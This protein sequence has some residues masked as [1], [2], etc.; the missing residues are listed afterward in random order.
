M[1]Q[2]IAADVTQF[3]A[4]V[5]LAFQRVESRLGTWASD[6][7]SY[8]SLLR[9]V[10]GEESTNATKA[11]AL[12]V[13]LRGTGL[14]IS[15]EILDGAILSGNKGAYTNSAPEG[16]ECIYLNIDWLQSATPEQIEAV[17]LEEIGH[18]IDIRLNGQSDSPGDEGEIF[19]SLIRSI[20]PNPSATTENDQSLIT[21]KGLTVAIEA[22]ATVQVALSASANGNE[23]D[24]SPVVFTFSRTGSTD[25]A[26][27]VGYQL[28]GSARAGSD[29]S[30][31]STGTITFAAGSATATLSL[32]ALADGALID[33]G[34]TIIARID[35]SGSYSITPFKQFATAT[36]T[37]EGM[38]VSPKA[39]RYPEWSSGEVN[40]RLAFA[41]LKSDGSVVSWGDSSTGGT[42]PTGLSGVTQ[43]F[44]TG[45][46]FAALKSDGSVVS[47]GNS[48][49]GGTAPTGLS[50]VT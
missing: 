2:L 7:G 48:S 11:M 1:P 17:L 8:N 50:G 25:A 30:G 47:W 39:S 14:A 23:A 9:E 43:I 6:S 32:P 21:I 10:F 18:A 22:S 26:L 24:G 36:I 13:E 5:Y 29:Y 44:S 4:R 16:G 27:S 45:Y 35:P 49:Y 28:F 19:S 15:V 12:L 42:T 41:A 31:S 37:A 38:L 33:P 46:A 40:N 20:N 34:E 3:F